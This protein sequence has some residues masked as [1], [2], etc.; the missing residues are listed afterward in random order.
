MTKREVIQKVNESLASFADD[1]E[2]RWVP[3]EEIAKGDPVKI[4]ALKQM[5]ERGE[6]PT[7]VGEGQVA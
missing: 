7:W 3:I 6:K 4:D 1:Q 2:V 5:I